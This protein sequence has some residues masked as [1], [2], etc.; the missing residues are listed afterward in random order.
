MGRESGRGDRILQ[1]EARSEEN[2]LLFL[3]QILLAIAAAYRGWGSVPAF[4]ILGS[5]LLGFVLPYVFGEG[6]AVSLQ[7][8]DFAVITALVAM[9]IKGVKR[10]A[11]A[12]ARRP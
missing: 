4:L 12:K 1:L 7:V 6:I 9:A 11:K 5:V 8:L 10:P 3:V 2:P